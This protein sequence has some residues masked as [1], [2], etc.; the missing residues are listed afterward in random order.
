L[1]N[2]GNIGHCPCGCDHSVAMVSDLREEGGPVALRS[3][4]DALHTIAEREDYGYITE[5]MIE[6]R[7]RLVALESE[8]GRPEAGRSPVVPP[9]RDDGPRVSNAAMRV[10]AD[11]V[12]HGDSTEIVNGKEKDLKA[13][14]LLRME[15]ENK[16]AREVTLHAPTLDASVPLPVSRWYVAGGDGEPW[17]GVLRGGETKLVHVIGYAGDRVAPGT[18]MATTVRFESSS[19]DATARAR[20]LLSETD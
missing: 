20:L 5:R 10:H 1:G 17:D 13:C 19:F 7:L 18:E 16:G 14:F 12:L 3:I 2:I 11:F 15:I 6:H 4:D 9:V 8:L